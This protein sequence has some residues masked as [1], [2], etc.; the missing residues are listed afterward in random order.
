M[1]SESRPQPA[2]VRRSYE[3]M[4]REQ[5][6]PALRDVG[7]TGKLSVFRFVGGDRAGEIR[8]QKDGRQARR[9]ITL[10][11]M[12]LNWLCGAG[13]ISDL[14]PLPATDTWW[15]VRGGYPT[16]AVAESVVSAVRCYA[17]PAILAGLDDPEPLPDSYEGYAGCFRPGRG[18]PELPDAGGADPR[19][20]F[21]QPA[22]VHADEYF[23]DLTS[24]AGSVR[25]T[26][27]QYITEWASGDARALPA[28]VDRLASDPA[29]YVRM[30]IASR[31][32]T[33]LADQPQVRAALQQAAAG[34]ADQV[35]RW[36]AR[37]ALRL[38]LNRQPGQEA[39]ARWP[40]QGGIEV[41]ARSDDPT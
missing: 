5:I 20:W 21:V 2:D 7:F 28:L 33:P 41:P 4:M 13:R 35:V 12:N 31:M 3:Q 18:G 17:V 36:A 6:A 10:F 26:A 38:D 39:L 24:T 25:L 27:A 29:Q 16:D 19:A 40:G 34:D 8:W 23:G 1:S 15:E 30:E 37:Y 9:Q 22:G 11:T 32:L 14:M